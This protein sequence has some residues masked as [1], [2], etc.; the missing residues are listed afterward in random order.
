[1]GTFC[2]LLLLMTMI[3]FTGYKVSVLEER[4]SEAVLQVIE[5]DHFDDN[6]SFGADQG[7]N[8]AIAVVNPF[9]QST[10]ET[11]DP[12]YG[13]IVFSSLDIA[14]RCFLR[15][16]SGSLEFYV[17]SRALLVVLRN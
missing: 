6:D 3:A 14:R 12:R 1:M 2:T 16:F 7:L 5:K 10:F 13:S 17:S 15:I 8:V 9:D 11:I 4:K